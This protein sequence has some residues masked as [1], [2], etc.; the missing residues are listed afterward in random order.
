MLTGY[1]AAG[2]SSP[3]GLTL[4]SREDWTSG[5]PWETDTWSKPLYSSPVPSQKTDSPSSQSCWVFL[6]H[7]NAFGAGEGGCPLCYL[8]KQPCATRVVEEQLAHSPSTALPRESLF[9]C[10]ATSATVSGVQRET[11]T[12]GRE[13]AERSSANG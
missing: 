10:G 8:S 7:R 12:R 11:L 1:P 6:K 9:M 2:P 13:P 3:R 5:S 4:V